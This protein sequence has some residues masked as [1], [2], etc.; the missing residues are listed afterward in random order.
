MH[1]S[2]WERLKQWWQKL[3]DKISLKWFFLFQADLGDDSL[4]VKA[5]YACLRYRHSNIVYTKSGFVY[6]ARCDILLGCAHCHK[7][8][9]ENK[10]IFKHNNKTY[11][12]HARLLVKE[13]TL[14]M[15]ENILEKIKEA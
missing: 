7:K 9:T 2:W 15:P 13:D 5:K 8:T 14:Y 1:E 12:W 11:R 3:K 4:R 10:V 6:C